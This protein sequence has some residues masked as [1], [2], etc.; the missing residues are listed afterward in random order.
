MEGTEYHDSDK[1][2][3]QGGLISPILANVYLHYSL[4]LWV[5]YVKPMLKGEVYYARYADDFIIMFQYKEDAYKVLKALEQRLAKF[6]L[7]LAMD[8]TRIIP[9]GRTSNNL[10]S[11]CPSASS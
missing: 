5:R 8:K 11:N 1:G 10:A 6:S 9:F 3:P 2:T 4:D 7:E